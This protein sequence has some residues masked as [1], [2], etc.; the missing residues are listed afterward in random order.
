MLLECN[1]LNNIITYLIELLLA[2][3]CA[4]ASRLRIHWCCLWSVVFTCCLRIRLSLGCDGPEKFQKLVAACWHAGSAEFLSELYTSGRLMYR[5]R[6]TGRYEAHLWDNSCRKE[7]QTRKGRQGMT[8]V[9]PCYLGA[10]FV[11]PFKPC[12]YGSLVQAICSIKQFI[13]ASTFAFQSKLALKSF[14]CRNISADPFVS[15]CAYCCIL[16]VY[17][18]DLQF[19]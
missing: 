7:G 14:F 8:L 1:F 17:I 10:R 18:N 6:W 11:E 13:G 4:E 3:H 19:I 5:H 2:I 16:V 9:C 15:L 12:S